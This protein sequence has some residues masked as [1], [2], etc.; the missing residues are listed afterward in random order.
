MAV[1]KCKMCGADLNVS[2]G[3]TVIECEYCGTRQTVSCSDD[4]KRINLYNRANRLRIN[5]EFDKAANIYESIVAEFPE[6]AEAYWGLV[7]CNYGIEY[8]DDPATAKK[9]PTC[10]RASFESIKNDENYKMALEYADVIAQKVYRDEAREIDRIR[11]EIL[12]ISKNEKPY[13]IFICYKETDEKG[14]RTIDSVI[15]QDVYDALTD[16]GY[17]VFFSRISLEDKLGRQYEPYIF[18]ALNSA[19]IML[20]F[21]TKYEYFHAV[22]VKNEWSRFLKLMAKDKSK[23]LIPCYKDMDAYDMPDEF[24]A[25]QAQD[26]GKVGALQD[27]VRGIGKIIEIDTKTIKNNASAEFDTITA[28]LLKR[29]FMFLEDGEFRNANEYCEK[30]LDI[31]PECAE[32]YLG[33]LMVEC[34]VRKEQQLSDYSEPFYNSDNYQKILRFGDANIA[35]RVKNYCDLINVRKQRDQMQTKYQTAC[36]IM[37]IAK[38]VEDYIKASEIFSLI[39]DFNDSAELKK[40][41][42]EK[43]DY[44]NKELK[45]NRARYILKNPKSLEEVKEAEKLLSEISDFKNAEKLIENDCKNFIKVYDLGESFKKIIKELKNDIERDKINEK[46][47]SLCTEKQKLEHIISN[48]ATNYQELNNIDLKIAEY[49][50]IVENSNE[51]KSLFNFK[52]K[53]VNI[54]YIHEIEVLKAKKGTIRAIIGRYNDVNE[55]KERI[56]SIDQEIDDLQIQKDNIAHLNIGITI[57]YIDDM[58]NS[59]ELKPFVLRT[60][61]VDFLGKINLMKILLSAEEGDVVC[62]GN[63]K[64]I[65]MYW[66]V[67]KKKGSKLMMLCVDCIDCICFNKWFGDTSWDH[68][69]L[70]QYLNYDF[71][72]E[73]FSNSERAAIEMS[74]ET[75]DK[76]FI[77]SVD[78]VEK[79]LL[80]KN[81]RMPRITSYLRRVLPF[82]SSK[83]RWWLRTNGSKP[84]QIAFVDGDGTI[85]TDGDIATAQY[86]TI[87]PAIWIKTP[88]IDL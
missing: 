52:K 1:F 46:I 62:Y 87:R 13:D 40:Q 42:Q 59:D 10:H 44:L 81:D 73:A 79:Y 83:C 23:V 27:L 65:P 21:G 39:I 26:L 67:V 34:S 77:F 19:K 85:N 43:I 78:E 56:Y 80:T 22:W 24:K 51:H 4:E 33:K 5:S 41:C 69:T 82:E 12:A 35:E 2:D 88:E 63:Y 38:S 72:K 48:F 32:A 37:N 49:T 54:D 74:E 57:D 29:V 66:Q 8:V 64:N 11:E 55:I 76:I 15:A 18:A 61:Y 75:H 50:Q 16:K 20:S 25:L 53:S 6:E 30:V 47:N 17:K 9:I 84:S 31:N 45:Y 36:N 70:R 7:I 28:P 58:F 71:Y 3:I 60:P 14:E 68:S 86:N